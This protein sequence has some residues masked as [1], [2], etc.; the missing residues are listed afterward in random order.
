MKPILRL[1]TL[2]LI[3]TPFVAQAQMDIDNVRNR[4]NRNVSFADS[5]RILSL[6][7]V[8]YYKKAKYKYDRQQIR[9]ER[10]TLEISGSATG[11]MTSLN[12]PWIETSGGDNSITLLASL[13]LKHVFTKDKFSLTT[14]FSGKFGYYRVLLDQTL[15]DGTVEQVPTWYKNQDEVWLSVTPSLKMSDNWSYGATVKFR[16]QF[17]DG[18]VSSGSQNDYNL[19]STFLSPGYLD[20]SGGL[21][22]DSPSDKYPFEIS[23]SPVA[24]SAIY[25]TS[26]KVKDNAQYSYG[27]PESTSSSYV[28]P[29]GVSPLSN[30]AYEGGSSVQIEYDKYFGKSK[31]LRYTTTLYTFYGWMTQLS[32]KNVYSDTDEYESA[33]TDWSD[34]GSVGLK[35]SLSI[36]PTVRWENKIEIKATS[37]ITTSL[38][39][40]LYY[41]KS[42]NYKIQTQSLLSV[43]LAYTFK[44]K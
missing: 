6:N 30:S 1:F 25:V 16:T 2:L 23:L 21:I 29:Y 27:N 20:I 37:L 8:D 31:Y 44:N 14:S 19:K 33:L 10:N 35:P 32:S 39:F 18:Y 28:E 26:D 9:K 42:Q 5:I 17:A 24:M 22:Y 36:S 40:Q 43:G 13:T 3:I 4:S 15:D 12:D 41:N 11:S 34:G 7:S 38:S